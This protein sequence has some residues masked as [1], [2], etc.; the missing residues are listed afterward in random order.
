VSPSQLGIRNEPSVSRQAGRNTG[1]FLRSAG[2]NTDLAPVL[3][4]PRGPQPFIASRA[5]GRDPISIERNGLAFASGL[6]SAGVAATAKH[7]PGL[8]R[9]QAT[10]DISSISIDTPK[11]ELTAD[12]VPFQR[13]IEI[14]IPLI[15]VS[16]AR[17]P[18]LDPF[19]AAAFSPAIIDHFL[20]QRLGYNGVVIT[21][22]IASPAVRHELNPTA[23]V[24]DSVR[25]GADI[26]LL[27][28]RP[29]AATAAYRALR[30]GLLR[31]SLDPTAMRASLRR[32]LTLKRQYAVG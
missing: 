22:D 20:R 32:I 31:G 16:T 26:A 28:H 25:A 15:M 19:N 6:N 4:V 30:R 17:Y 10:T 23:A 2:I 9:A 1:L 21:D 13:G 11:A 8:G 3:D 18:S 5:F 14:R 27:A 7:F 24:V 12:L 29:A